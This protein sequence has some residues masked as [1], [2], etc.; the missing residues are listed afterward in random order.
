M[1]LVDNVIPYLLFFLPVVLIIFLAF[2]SGRRRRK[3][4]LQPFA[5]LL[6]EKSAEVENHFD[7]SRREGHFHGRGLAFTAIEGSRD[8]PSKLRVDLSCPGPLDF[9]ISKERGADKFL[10]K[11]H[12]EHDIEIGDPEMDATFV[13]ASSDP[14]RFASWARRSEVQEQIK[15]LLLTYGVSRLTLQTG[16]LDSLFVGSRGPSRLRNGFPQ[17]NMDDMGVILASMEKLAA[18]LASA[19]GTSAPPG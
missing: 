12:L 2:Y 4:I 9:K 7:S 14:D 19:F 6:D 18:A 1:T 13:F 8:T 10:K 5:S 3:R 15:S 16:T 17:I 11:L